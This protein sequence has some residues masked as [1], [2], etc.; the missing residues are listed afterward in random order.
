MTLQAIGKIISQCMLQDD[1]S[2]WEEDFLD[3]LEKQVAD[4]KD[5][6]AKQLKKLI[7]IDE[8]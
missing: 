2:E 5:L 4:G 6:S 7:E 1:L 3:S 8:R